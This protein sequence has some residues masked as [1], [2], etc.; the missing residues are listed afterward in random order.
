VRVSE[1][2]RRRLPLLEQ[3]LNSFVPAALKALRF[4]VA[5][6]V[7]AA[8]L[9][10][11]DIVDFV[12][13]AR[14]EAG[15]PIVRSLAWIAAILLAAWV[16]WLLVS[17]WVEYRLNREAGGPPTARER[18]LLAL[19]S[20][21]FVIVLLL[22]TVFAV[23]RELGVNVAPLIAGAGVIG[24]AIGFG[25][26][27]LVQD[28]INGAFIQFENTMN[29][30]DVVT[31]GPI[32]GAVEKLTIRSVSLR[33]LNGVVHM[34]PF[35]SVDTVSNFTKTFS[36][37]V[38]DI[39]VAYREDIA[40]VKQAMQDAFDRLMGTANRAHVL[41]PFE[42]FGVETFAESAV[43]VRG[44]IKTLPGQQWT[45]GRAYNEVVK[46]VFDERGIEIPFPHRTL[47]IGEDREG[48]APPLNLRHLRDAKRVPQA[49][50]GIAAPGGA[51]PAAQARLPLASD[52]D[53]DGNADGN[54][55][56]EGR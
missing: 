36:F 34:I 53:A 33:D 46:A 44:R 31:A 15:W 27:K 3:R 55:D 28:I 21:A 5:V 16:V 43:I 54:A 26:Q 45:V 12:G 19:F 17:S 2:T 9:S 56:G 52:G 38:A 23:L 40:E 20:N 35:S 32:T 22:V 10:A 29:E 7:I 42:M 8:I 50:K 30:G 39:G 37:H 11:W 14:S 48:N 49:P 4:A 25:A 1:G 6:V 47:Y 41:P 18:T 51:L 24:L 13:W